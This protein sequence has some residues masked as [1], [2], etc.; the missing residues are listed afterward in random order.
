MLRSVVV[1]TL[2]LVLAAGLIGV[3]A[4]GCAKKK[5]PTEYCAETG[6]C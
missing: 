5:L 6:N 4:S 2:W 1:R 3:A